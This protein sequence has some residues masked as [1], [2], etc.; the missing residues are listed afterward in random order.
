MKKQPAR[1]PF[2][3][4]LSTEEKAIIENKSKALGLSANAYIR[5]QIFQPENPDISSKR[6]PLANAAIPEINVKIYSA[7]CDIANSL[8]TIKSLALKNNP[9]SFNSLSVDRPLIDETLQLVKKIGLQLA[10]NKN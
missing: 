7:L 8:R 2:T 4:L 9:I 1:S 10:S 5:F 6:S 3:L